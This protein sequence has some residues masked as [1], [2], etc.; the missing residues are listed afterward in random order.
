[1][2]TP[3]SEVNLQLR[4]VFGFNYQIKDNLSYTDDNTL[5]YIAGHSFILHSLDRNRQRHIQSSEICD[6][7]QAYASGPGKR[8]AVVAERGDQPIFHVFDLRTNRRKKSIVCSE[9]I[10]TDIISMDISSDNQLILV[11]GGAPD[12]VLMCWNWAKTKLVASVDC[13]SSSGCM[14][15]CRFSPLDASIATVTGKEYVKFFRVGEKEIRPLHENHMKDSSYTCS[16]WMRT[17]DDHLLAAT[18]KGSISIFRSG[19]H[20]FDLDCA[21]GERMPIYCIVSIPKGFICGTVDATIIIFSYDDSYDQVLYNT[22]FTVLNTISGFE[23]A[24]GYVLNIAIDTKDA[25][26]TYITSDQQM[27]S[28]SIT[29]PGYIKPESLAYTMCNFHGNKAITGMDIAQT[30]P[31]IIT[32]SRDLTLRL[33]NIRTHSLEQCKMFPE[34]MFSCAI[35]PNGLHCAVGFADK[36]RIYHLLVDDIR[37][38]MEVAIKSCREV[39]FSI[40]GNFIAAANGNSIVVYDMYSGDKVCDLKGHNSKVRNIH[41]L[42]SGYQLLSSGQDGA[43]Y[44]W[45]LEGARRTGEFVQKGVVYTGAVVHGNNVIAVGNDRSIRE[46][47]FPDCTPYKS[48][49]AGFVLQQIVSVSTKNALIAAS[50]EFNK[51]PGLRV[52]PYPLT[53]DYDTVFCTSGQ[54]TRLRLSYDENFLVT[55][56]D[57]GCMVLMEIKSWTD[58]FN[59]GGSDTLPELAISTEWTD[60][61]LVTRAELEEYTGN[62][63]ELRTKVE[64]LKLNNEYI[65][66]LKDMNYAE[67]TKETTDKFVQELELAKSKLELLKEIRSDVEIEALEKMRY[68]DEMHKSDLQTLESGFQSEIIDMVDIYQQLIRNRDGQIERLDTQRKQIVESHEKYVDELTNNYELKLGDDKGDRQ[69]HEDEKKKLEL[70]LKEAQNQLE[71]DIDTEIEHGIK[72]FEDRLAIARER[73][74][75]YKGENGIMKK[76]YGLLTRDV[77]DQKEEVKILQ[78]KEK[79][80]LD[81]IKICEKEVSVHKKEIKSRDIS[82]GDKE[83]RIYDLKKKNMELDKFKYVLDFKIRELKEQ[84]EPR[85]IEILSMRENIKNLDLELENNHKSNAALDDL[86]GDVR[87]KIDEVQEEIKRFRLQAKGLEIMMSTFRKDLNGAMAHVMTPVLLEQA[88]KAIVLKYGSEDAIRPRIDFEIQNEYDRHKK[89]LLRSVKEL[90]ISVKIMEEERST[91]TAELRQK[92]MNLITEINVE[93]E[94]NKNLKNNLQADIARVR[95]ISQ[96]QQNMMRKKEQALKR[97]SMSHSSKGSGRPGRGDKDAMAAWDPMV[98]EDSISS[99]EAPNPVDMLDHN[100]RRILALN[101]AIKQLQIKQAS[102]R[103]SQLEQE[104]GGKGPAYS[105]LPEI[106]PQSSS[107]R[108]SFATEGSGQGSAMLSLPCVVPQLETDEDIIIGRPAPAQPTYATE[109]KSPR[110]H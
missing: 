36:L 95:H 13:R 12:W 72:Q 39:R 91:G 7:I 32:C 50:Y 45:S 26:L 34:E 20:V 73:T 94:G 105:S 104:Q 88:I 49:D 24:Q 30:K 56:D 79:E 75:K 17:P 80:L 97:A 109:Y 52:Y 93:R 43:V 76:K 18:D 27:I 96:L 89:Y 55:T 100:R 107:R 101:A 59:R 25:N 71:D 87:I 14:V 44:L 103:I 47:S 78:M 8:I 57:H 3:A 58:R 38:C 2:S 106:G 86:I 83:R 29:E 81:Q 92:N 40:G 42:R 99:N 65:L 82:V 28:V 22:Q 23:L 48:L 68:M 110:P 102:R 77:E 11:L 60:E 54:T 19:E 4:Y 15:N 61:I 16:C 66:K 108:P 41:W 5:A 69:L 6:P 1:M 51:P 53:G 98:S 10:S 62:A 33:W 46:L 64:E 90:K 21:P 74:L 84:I 85:Q 35:H 9:I 67:K 63:G 31:L 70:E 37:L